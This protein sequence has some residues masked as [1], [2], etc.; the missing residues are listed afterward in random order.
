ML[1]FEQTNALGQILDTSWA[2][3]GGAGVTYSL[4]DNILV[5]KYSTV[6][7]FASEQSLRPQVVRLAEESTQLLSQ[8]VKDLKSKFKEM[9]GE[10]LKLKERFNRD[11]VELIQASSVN[12]R[13]V[14]YYRRNVELTVEN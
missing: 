2:H 8:V 5:L 1:T 7:H 4:Q 6:V 14:A 11:D 3:Q 13:R 10:S 9:T 12:P